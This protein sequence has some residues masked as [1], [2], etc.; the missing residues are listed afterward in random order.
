MSGISEELRKEI[1]KDIPGYDGLYQVSNLGRVKSLSYNGTKKE[2]I[3][4]AQ[5]NTG[6]YLH[7][8]LKRKTIQVHQLVAMTF[9]GHI[10]C[11]YK[12]VV[13]HINDIR[14]DNRVENLQIVTAR[15]NTCKTRGKYSS[16]YKG[17]SFEKRNSKWRA[18]IEV[19]GRTINLGYFNCELSAH[20]SYQNK[21]KQIL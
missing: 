14:T 21:L 15:F 8:N 1:W 16:K 4:K 5:S 7:V 6:T 12:L 19:N 11:G 3:L 10:P 17:V 18:R 13:D 9:L 2:K 20:L